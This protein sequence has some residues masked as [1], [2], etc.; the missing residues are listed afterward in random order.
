MRMRIGGGVKWEEYIK[1]AECIEVDE[2]RIVEEGTV[3]IDVSGDRDKELDF[4]KE[5]LIANVRVMTAR[6][7][8]L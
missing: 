4:R 8:S 7:K 1:S 2:E 6:Y 5:A 3:F